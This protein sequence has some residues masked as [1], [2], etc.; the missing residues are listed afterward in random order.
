VRAPTDAAAANGRPSTRKVISEAVETAH[1]PP[2]TEE[3]GGRRSSNE[4]TAHRPPF[5]TEISRR[6]S[7]MDFVDEDV[8]HPNRQIQFLCSISTPLPPPRWLPA[9]R[10]QQEPFFSLGTLTSTDLARRLSPAT[11]ASATS[12]TAEISRRR[13]TDSRSGLFNFK[14]QDET[15]KHLATR[16]PTSLPLAAGHRGRRRREGERPVRWVA[17]GSKQRARETGIHHDK[18]EK[19]RSLYFRS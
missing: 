19:Q 3:I 2:L 11:N 9:S 16:N 12:S 6:R 8:H 4:E 15:T 1:Q 17:V 10:T 14:T 5:S 7:S 13:R 18:A